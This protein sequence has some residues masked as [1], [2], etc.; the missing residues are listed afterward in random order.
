MPR[1]Q[2][3]GNLASL[4]AKV[5]AYCEV[6]PEATTMHGLPQ[7]ATQLRQNG[8][9][10]TLRALAREVDAW[11]R[12]IHTPEQQSAIAAHMIARGVLESHL[13]A[14][15]ERTVRKLIRRGSISSQAEAE[16]VKQLLFNPDLAAKY[17]SEV[18]GLQAMLV[19][20][21]TKS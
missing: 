15:V 10:T 17:A 16:F 4:E 9:L 14:S 5:H 19:P 12:E 13:P 1:V 20:W 18:Q 6:S 11:L 21:D 7:Y 8:D 3:A 2:K